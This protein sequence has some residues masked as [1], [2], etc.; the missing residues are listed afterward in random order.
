MT[1]TL[2]TAPG[3][4][5]HPDHQIRISK[6]DRN[7]I[8]RISD[9]VIAGSNRAL[10]L[11]ETGYESAIYFPPED[12]TLDRMQATSD[13]TTCPFKGEANYFADR[14]AAAE[15]PVA[16]TY[17]AVYDEVSAI[18]GYIAFYQ[19]RVELVEQSSSIK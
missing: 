8:V 9:T 17:P 12:V 13:R 18:A 15:P 10:V 11:Q 16:W 5:N 14:N 3:S 1:T 2:G 7:W 6:S 4:V 19:D